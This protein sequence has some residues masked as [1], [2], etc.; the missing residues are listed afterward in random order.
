MEYNHPVLIDKY[1]RHLNYLRISVTDRCNLRCIYCRPDGSL[2][3]LRHDDI[4]S[5]EE[6]YR[7]TEIAVGLGINKVRLTG[8]EPLV[9]KGITEF[10]SRVSSLHG[11]RELSLTTNGIYLKDNLEKIRSAGIKRINISLDTLDREKYVKI[12]G[13]DGFD[14]VWEGI[15]LARQMGFHPIKINMVPIKGLNDDEIYEFARMTFKYPYH[16]RFIELMP[17]GAV[18][19]DIRTNF[20]PNTLI[21]ARISELG[22]LEPVSRSGFDGPAE[23]FKYN[24]ALGEIGFISPLTEHFCRICNRLRLTSEGH[25]RVCLLSDHEEDLKGPMRGGASDDD[26][27]R[28]FLSAVSNK[29]KGHNLDSKESLLGQ[30]SEIGG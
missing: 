7:L 13:Y 2:P 12:T 19:F 18:K 17:L 21:K 16:V 30:M 25:L 22:R 14:L 26:L 24:G 9:R 29:P 11:L 15:E 23:R 28:I 3:K 6:I 20:L 27:R 5:Y 8:G 1:D 10:I 4:L